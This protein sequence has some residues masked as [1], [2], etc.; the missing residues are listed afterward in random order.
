MPGARVFSCSQPCGLRLVARLLASAS[1][2]GRDLLKG[3]KPSP[4]SQPA[5]HERPVG[6]SKW[7]F[8]RGEKLGR[9][10][11]GGGGLQNSSRLG[12]EE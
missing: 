1:W 9:C 10:G 4:R 6:W 2:I 8:G 7:G 12:S 5:A 3:V 11:R